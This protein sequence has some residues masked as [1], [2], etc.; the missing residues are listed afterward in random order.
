MHFLQAAFGKTFNREKVVTFLKRAALLAEIYG[1]FCGTGAN[2]GHL[3][4][5]VCGRGV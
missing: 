3:L 2:S 4:Q 1:G 5:L